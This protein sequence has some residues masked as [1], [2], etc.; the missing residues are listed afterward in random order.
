VNWYGT[1]SDDNSDFSTSIEGPGN[2][3]QL[4][5]GEQVFVNVTILTR[6]K[7]KWDDLPDTVNIKAD[8]SQG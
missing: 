7:P 8:A 4:D 1:E 2:A 3:Y 5:V 6:G